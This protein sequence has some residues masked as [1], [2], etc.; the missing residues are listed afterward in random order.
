MI[1]AESKKKNWFHWVVD[2]DPD[3]VSPAYRDVMMPEEN[4]LLDALVEFRKDV[5]GIF[6][7]F[8]TLA[9]LAV[10]YSVRALTFTLSSGMKWQPRTGVS[11]G[12]LSYAA[13]FL[14]RLRP[15][16]PIRAALGCRSYTPPSPMKWSKGLTEKSEKFSSPRKNEIVWQISQRNILESNFSRNAPAFLLLWGYGEIGKRRRLKIFHC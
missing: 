14:F 4:C 16:N 12:T 2:H 10:P 1:S 15:P 9:H 6:P 13:F 7:D 8:E 11:V 3:C 5:G